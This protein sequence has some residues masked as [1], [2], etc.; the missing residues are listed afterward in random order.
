LSEERKKGR[1]KDSSLL[2]E[3]AGFVERYT[4]E[5]VLSENVSGIGDAKYGGVWDEFRRR[6]E[7]LGYVTG[8]KVVCVSRFGIPQYR[9]RS[10]LVAVRRE[11]IRPEHLR[12]L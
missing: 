6:L 5:M 8:S 3:A 1:D 11:L 10:I 2:R 7:E 9:K 12:I 4:P